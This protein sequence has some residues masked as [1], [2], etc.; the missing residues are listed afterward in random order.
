M[1]RKPRPRRPLSTAEHATIEATLLHLLTEA[2]RPDFTVYTN[3]ADFAQAFG[4]LEGLVKVGILT[5][6]EAS[7]WRY[8]LE[9]RIER[10]PATPREPN[11]PPPYIVRTET[12]QLMLE[13]AIRRVSR[14]NVGARPGLRGFGSGQSD[15]RLRAWKALWDLMRERREAA[16]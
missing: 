12:P 1:T 15:M 9:R 3:R 4:I 10:E 16:P 7:L 14:V 2:R 5:E 13:E 6:Q 11:K 8:A